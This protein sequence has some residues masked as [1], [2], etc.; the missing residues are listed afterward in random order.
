MPAPP[1]LFQA[2]GSM[3]EKSLFG[4]SVVAS[5]NSEYLRDDQRGGYLARIGDGAT[6]SPADANDENASPPDSATNGLTVHKAARGGGVFGWF[7]RQFGD[8]DAPAPR[9]AAPAPSAPLPVPVDT[10]APRAVPVQ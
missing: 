10:D 2:R 8:D 9:P 3:T 6:T 1:G 5:G 7:R 4:T